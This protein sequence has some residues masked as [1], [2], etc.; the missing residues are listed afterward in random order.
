MSFNNNSN[1]EGVEVMY[2]CDPAKLIKV[3]NIPEHLIQQA[4]FD[5][6]KCGIRQ[7]LTQD[8]ADSDKLKTKYSPDNKF[9]RYIAMSC[10]SEKCRKIQKEEVEIALEWHRLNRIDRQVMSVLNMTDP[11]DKKEKEIKS[12]CEPETEFDS[13]DEELEEDGETYF[14]CAGTCGRVMHYEDTNEFQMCGRCE[15]EKAKKK[16]RRK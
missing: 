10:F 3:F 5:C 15:Y 11:F 1:F 2:A 12:A 9:G 13:W 7:N 16:G 4:T 8:M 14:M 6:E